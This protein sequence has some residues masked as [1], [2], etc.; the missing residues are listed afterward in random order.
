[1]ICPTVVVGQTTL[2]ITDGE[3]TIDQSILIPVELTTD[4]TEGIEGISFT[5]SFDTL[6]LE[7]TGIVKTNAISDSLATVANNIGEEI[8]VSLSSIHPVSESGTLIFLEFTPK[9]VGDSELSILKFRINENDTQF[10]TTETSTVRVF[11]LDGNQPPFVVDVPDTVIIFTGD[12]LRLV[13][14]DSFVAD[15]EDQLSDL[16][17]TADIDPLVL[18]PDFNY[19]SGSNLLTVAPV[20]FVGF[21][22]LSLTIEDSNG[23]VLNLSIVLDI[24]LGVSNEELSGQAK[25][26]RLEQNYPNPF[27]PSTNISYVIPEATQVTVEVFN[28]LGER[29]AELVNKL[30]ASGE[31]SVRFDATGLTSGIYIYRINAGSFI[32]TK[33]MLLVK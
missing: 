30:Q 33:K 20:S 1:M 13:I 25:E 7:Y 14:D 11:G 29:V 5:V 10:P 21:A 15:A 24:R 17:I 27:N 32:S 6:A 2:S 26:F 3:T 16:S 8:L 18:L 19:D 23:G 28:L 22:T 12:T 4:G 9:V 31:H